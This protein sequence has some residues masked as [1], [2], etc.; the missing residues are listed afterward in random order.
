[1][2]VLLMSYSPLPQGSQPNYEV[3]CLSDADGTLPSDG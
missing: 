3:H 2:I 1:M